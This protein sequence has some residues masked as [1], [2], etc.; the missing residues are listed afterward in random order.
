MELNEHQAS[1]M[2]HKDAATLVLLVI[3]FLATGVDEMTKR[4]AI[5]VVH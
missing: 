1:G 5:E 4:V 2:V 3:T